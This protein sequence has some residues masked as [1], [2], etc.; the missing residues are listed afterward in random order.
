MPNKYIPLKIPH[1]HNETLMGRLWGK[2]WDAASHK[3]N[4]L[5][6]RK[7]CMLT[8]HC[9]QWIRD[10]SGKWLLWAYPPTESNYF[11][12][13]GTQK[14]NTFHNPIPFPFTLGGGGYGRNNYFSCTQPWKVITFC[15]WIHG[16]WLGF[17][18]PTLQSNLCCKKLRILFI[19][20]SAWKTS[21]K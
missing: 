19:A 1:Y 6:G 21:F 16:K 7:T 20:F 13:W 9:I 14:L 18:C 2:S 17:E 10:S 5:V 4:R 3:A 8:Y 15:G 11:P 12:M